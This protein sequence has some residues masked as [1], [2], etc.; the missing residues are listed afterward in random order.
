[1][2]HLTFAGV[3]AM[4]ANALRV[5]LIV[6]VKAMKKVKITTMQVVGFTC[7]LSAVL[8]VLMTFITPLNQMSVG[9]SHTIE[10]IYHRT[11]YICALL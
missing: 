7:V 10:A 11:V 2:G 6:N 1:M 5:H 9:S 4:L 3:T 8:I